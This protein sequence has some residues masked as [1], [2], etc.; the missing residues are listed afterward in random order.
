VNSAKGSMRRAYFVNRRVAGFWLNWEV[1]ERHRDS[2]APELPGEM[3][4]RCGSIPGTF[5]GVFRLGTPSNGRQRLRFGLFEADL[6]SGELYRRGRLI[7]LQDQPFRILSMLLERPGEV[8]TREEVRK[9]LWPDGTF[10]DFDEGLDTALKKLRQALGDSSNNPTFIETVPRRGYR[11]IA[12]VSSE[13][14]VPEP[15]TTPAAVATSVRARKPLARTAAIAAATAVPLLALFLFAAAVVRTPAPPRVTR[16]TKI[17]EGGKVE[18]WA[19]PVTDGSRV[20]FLEREGGHWNL[21]QS[22]AA[23]GT[24]QPVPAVLPN[25][26]ILDVSPDQSRFLVGTFLQRDTPMKIWIMPAQGGPLERVGD[27]VAKF[28]TWAPN[29]KQIVYIQGPDLMLCDADGRNARKIVSA[30]G[31]MGLGVWSPDG[32][33]LRFSAWDER[34]ET[35]SLWEAS[36]DG[37]HP[38]RMFPDS[39]ATRSGHGE[40]CGR[41]TPDGRYFVFE[42]WHDGKRNLWA[43]REKPRFFE[44]KKP[45]PVQLTAGPGE[46]A[47]PVLSRDGK[48]VFAHQFNPDPEN[49]A[50]RFNPRDH[51]LNPIPEATHRPPVWDPRGEW[52]VYSDPADGTLW[53]SRTDGSQ[54]IQVTHAPLHVWGGQWSPDGAQIL[55]SASGTDGHAQVYTLASDG[56]EP[57]LLYPRPEHEVNPV[58]C[59]NGGSILFRLEPIE[60]ETGSLYILELTTQRLQKVPD[61]D[62]LEQGVCSADGQHILGVTDDYRKLKMYSVRTQKWTELFGGN[63]ISGPRWAP[64]SKSFFYQDLLGEN[65][66]I[67]RFWLKENRRE[68]VFDFHEQFKMGYFRGLFYS[69]EPDGTLLFLISKGAADLYALDLELP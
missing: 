18:S 31:T 1:A 12:P 62:G 11:F 24:P 46:F 34:T 22:S 48:R 32:R 63:M 25:T 26:R 15:A 33:V 23:G 3:P 52:I 29:G 69:L 58:W 35:G 56:F 66:P 10:V 49:L 7:H 50:W 38:H 4:Y 39:P 68:T 51:S 53:R 21:M 44:G 41:W 17:T 61:S 8:V 6:A 64:D 20:Y 36:A 2:S 14:Q 16:I 43:L 13:E 9:K 55:F 57:K 19:S 27:L 28:A 60:A 67:Y 65:E 37:S 59:P 30:P 5:G 45:S 42:A 54:L 40:C 47:S